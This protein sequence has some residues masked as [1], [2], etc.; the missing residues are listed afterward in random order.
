MRSVRTRYGG[1]IRHRSRFSRRIQV[2]SCQEFGDCY[3]GYFVV[4]RDG[5]D[6]SRLARARGAS[7][8]AFDGKFNVEA[9]AC[10]HL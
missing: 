2:T 10:G 9:A 8:V 1:E 5:W 4:S 3:K 7:L 6:M